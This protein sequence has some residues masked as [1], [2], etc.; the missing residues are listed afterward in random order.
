M[1]VPDDCA[2]PPAGC[3][4]FPAELLG[5]VPLERVGDALTV[6]LQHDFSLRNCDSSGK[7]D[8]FSYEMVNGKVGLLGSVRPLSKQKHQLARRP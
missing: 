6:I 7:V 5:C 2:S 1:A 3:L 4:E 8:E